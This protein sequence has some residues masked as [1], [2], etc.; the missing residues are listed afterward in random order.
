[1]VNITWFD[2]VRHVS[3]NKTIEDPQPAHLRELNLTK[4]GSIQ[5]MHFDQMSDDLLDR[6]IRST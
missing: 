1:L 6:S 2:S 3:Y 4:S 5:A